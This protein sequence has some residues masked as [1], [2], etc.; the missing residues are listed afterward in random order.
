MKPKPQK[1]TNERG[2]FCQRLDDLL[3]ME[4]EIVRLAQAMD[5][6]PLLESFGPLY[7]DQKGRPGVPIRLM[8]GIVLLQHTFGVSDE[9]VVETWVQNPYW[10]YFCGEEFFQHAFPID[11]SSLSRWRGRIGKEGVERLLALSIQAGKKT[12]TVTEK[13]MDIVIV[14]TTVQPKAVAHPTDA[15]LYVKALHALVRI[16]AKEGIKLRQTYTKSAKEAQFLYGRYRKAKHFKKAAREQK[17][18]KVF[19][20]RVLRDLERKMSDE[21]FRFHKGTMILAE[22]VLTQEKKTKGKVYSMHAPETECI[23]KGKAHKPYEFGV[24]TS[25][26]VTL[27]SGFVVGAMSCPGN[28]FDGHTLPGQLEQVK[29]LT[30]KMPKRSHV[31]RGYKGHGVDPESCEVLISGGRRGISKSLRRQMKRRS[32]VEPEI[33]HQKFDGKLGR[34]WLKGSFGDALNPILCGAGHNLRKILAKLRRSLYARILSHLRDWWA[35]INPCP[36][37]RILAHA[38]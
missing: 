32:A 4:H 12:K 36:Y 20:G 29:R 24:K 23:A 21:A 18:L 6:D 3:N 16:A 25:L 7:A 15:R 26:A 13:E 30:G 14:D 33:G 17:K 5:W 8:A 37:S 9:K 35:W 10:Q 19:A 34:N 2:M 31:D 28:P 1:K 27:K 38:A 22:L 11:P